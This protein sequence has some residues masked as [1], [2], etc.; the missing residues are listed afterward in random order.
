[1][2]DELVTEEE[3]DALRRMAEKGMAFGRG[4]GGP[5]IF[6]VATGAASRGEQ[7]VNAYQMMENKWKQ[8]KKRLEKNLDT[9]S[10]EERAVTINA[11]SS[12]I[13]TPSEIELYR[14]LTSRIRS[15]ISSEFGAEGL[16]L[17]SPSFFSRLTS[18]P[19]KTRHDEYWHEHVDKK[20]YGSFIYTALIYLSDHGSDF[21]GGEFVFVD[22]E[23]DEQG[24]DQKG[25][26]DM[27]RHIVAKPKKGRVMAFTSGRENV[28]MVTPVTRGIRHALT[29]AFTCDQTKS[30]EQSLMQ[31]ATTM[32]EWQRQWEKQL[33]IEKIPQTDED[34]TSDA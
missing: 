20:Q 6:D 12:I 3:V 11:T 25:S 13:F 18:A 23:D 14:S 1:M 24:I 29:I 33:Q 7:F 8:T 5:T 15:L 32:A 30:V 17:T 4:S 21:D 34:K 10:A 19:A 9:M 2:R 31:Q 26:N 27:K 22:D 16:Y 28:H